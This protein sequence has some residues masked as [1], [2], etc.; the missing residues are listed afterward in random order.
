[1]STFAS[2]N[3]E[4]SESTLFRG[5]WAPAD[6]SKVCS[7]GFLVYPGNTD[8]FSFSSDATLAEYAWPTTVIS[9]SLPEIQEPVDGTFAKDLNLSYAPVTKAQMNQNNPEVTSHNLCALIKIT[10]PAEDKDVR[11]IRIK[12]ANTKLVGNRSLSWTWSSSKQTLSV[13]EAIS[14]YDEVTLVRENSEALTPGA[15]YYAVVWPG[16]A[17]ELTLTFSDSNGGVCEKRVNAT[18][19]LTAGGG[20]SLNIKSLDMKYQPEL[21]VDATT[22]NLAAS[23]GSASFNV[24]ANNDWTVVANADWLAVSPASGVA[25]SLEASV[26]VTAQDN[27]D[28]TSSRSAVVIVAAGGLEHK[29]TVTQE[30][31][32]RPKFSVGNEI[33]EA[34]QLKDGGK[35]VLRAVCGNGNGGNT[36]SYYF[37]VVDSNGNVKQENRYSNIWSDRDLEHVFEYKLSGNDGVNDSNYNSKSAGYWKSLATGKYMSAEFRFDADVDS[38]QK[39]ALANKWKTETASG[40]DFYKH[41]TTVALTT[42][43]DPSY[44]FKWASTLDK[45]RKWI[46]Y[47]VTQK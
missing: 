8:R 29:I 3:T 40:L 7:Y 36:L 15:S 4:P 21:K 44:G 42:G 26:T 10:L 19:P 9:Y 37:W 17:P 32:Q 33:T 24:L 45:Y 13:G 2:L 1:M 34:S 6:I 39:F 27:T 43:D 20:L 12:S 11:S 28:Y 30:A 22:L 47:E 14:E 38:A 18:K 46:I 31:G 35:Y 23:N 5:D 41:G 16:A 25:S